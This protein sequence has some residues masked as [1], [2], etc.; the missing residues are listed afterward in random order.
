MSRS[1]RWLTVR[2][3][4]RLRV[5]TS[6]ASIVEAAVG[7]LRPLLFDRPMVRL[8]DSECAAKAASFFVRIRS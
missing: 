1:E 3:R 4:E 5:Y 2:E 8:A 6:P 7:R